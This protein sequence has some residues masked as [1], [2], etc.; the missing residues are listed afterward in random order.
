[1]KTDCQT[2]I[3][4]ML[5][6]GN[7]LIK[8]S[9]ILGEE[10]GSVNAK[11][12][13]TI[14]MDVKIEQAIIDYVRRNELPFN[15][16]SEEIGFINI[17]PKPQ[18]VLVFDP[19]DGSTNYRVGKGLFPYGLMIALYKGLKPKLCD[20]VSSGF[21]EHTTN[22]WWT[23][24]GSKT[25][26]S[27]GKVVILSH[28]WKVHRSTPVHFDL[29]YK[30][31]Y[32]TFS[33]LAEKIHIRWGGSNTS[34]LLY[35]LSETSAAMGALLMRPEE[36]GT[37]VSLIKGAGGITVDHKGKDLGNYIFSPDETYQL[38]AGDKKIVEFA[39]SQ[40]KNR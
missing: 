11:G 38:L 30:K 16:F 37:V 28:N 1:M 40:L 31:A 20:I 4:E 25:R 5:E 24:D 6:I 35:V 14:E 26:D 15:I 7:K 19:L 21:A 2:Y 29:Y 17:H 8:E 32:D 34:S 33:S 12:D 13:K 3:K 9:P 18:Y 39:V 27:H 22:K 23:Y 10:T 36:I